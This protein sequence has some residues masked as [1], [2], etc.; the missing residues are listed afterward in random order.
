L[1][2]TL[3]KKKTNI[4][5]Q[6]I[7]EI[8]P[9][10]SLAALEQSLK[11]V[12]ETRTRSSFL[13][14]FNYKDE[15]FVF[16]I[17]IFPVLSGRREIQF[18]C[19]YFEDISRWIKEQ[20]LLQQQ[21]D[22]LQFYETITQK[23]SGALLVLNQDG[24]IIFWNIAA[25][26]LTGYSK[27]EV[28]NKPFEKFFL[29]ID[30]TAL[31]S[32]FSYLTESEK[33]Q[34]NGSLLTK[35]KQ[36][37]EIELSFFAAKNR[38]SVPMYVLLCADITEKIEVE[39]A[40][41]LSEERFRSIV[42]NAT[43]LICNFSESGKIIYANPSFY[44]E[45]GFTEEE[46][47]EKKLQDLIEATPAQQKKFSIKQIVQGKINSAELTFVKKDGRLL[48][49]LGNF[50]VTYDAQK[51]IKDIGGIFSDITA[52]KA[53]EQE[54][55]LMRAIFEA[56]NDGIA[57]ESDNSFV[58]VNNSF[59]KIF[60]YEKGDDLLNTNPMSLVDEADYKRIKGYTE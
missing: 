8:F 47:S 54:L 28:Y 35:Q 32:I 56:S 49:A 23:S 19:F 1:F 9:K 55:L 16:D 46:L 41:R 2:N 58:I 18:I 40:L 38:E 44:H 7:Q 11:E 21:I 31:I 57:V 39:R 34:T 60:G 13:S 51:R 10:E 53:F 15:E 26:K 4:L 45:L 22:E 42:Q 36:K 20:D 37:R 43:D 17:Q 29:S 14:S 6:P 48:E 27:S 5:Q 12:K 3:F 24:K 52:K 59:A 30:R 50:S 25:E 33:Y